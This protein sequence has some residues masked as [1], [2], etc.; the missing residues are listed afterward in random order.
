MGVFFFLM[1]QPSLTNIRSSEGIRKH[2]H[3]KIIYR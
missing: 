2:K 3:D 1:F